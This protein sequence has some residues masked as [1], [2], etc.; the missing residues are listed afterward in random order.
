MSW[1]YRILRHTDPDSTRVFAIHEV[2]Y[3]AQGEPERWTERAAAPQGESY[4][5]LTLDLAQYQQAFQ[6]HVLAVHG[7]RL[8]DVGPM[9]TNVVKILE[10]PTGGT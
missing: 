6:R 9:G 8:V 4:K 2:Y 7:D 10:R 1:N 3:D 5:E